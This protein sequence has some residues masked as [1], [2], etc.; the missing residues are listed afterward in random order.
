MKVLLRADCRPGGRWQEA[1]TYERLCLGCL[2]HFNGTRFETRKAMNLSELSR[3]LLKDKGR[4]LL[5]Y[6]IIFNTCDYYESS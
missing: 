2:I 4:G 6:V 5:T 3:G 1:A